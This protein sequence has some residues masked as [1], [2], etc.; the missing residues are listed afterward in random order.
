MERTIIGLAQR[1]AVLLTRGFGF[2]H[3]LEQALLDYELTRNAVD[4]SSGSR[5]C[6][7][8]ILHLSDLHVDGL[9]DGGRRLSALLELTAAD[10][11]LITGD[12]V[13]PAV[14]DVELVRVRLK[15]ILS[16]MRVAHGAFAVL[17]GHDTPHIAEILVDA[18]VTI[19]GAAT[20]QVR[21]QQWTLDLVAA[22]SDRVET[23]SL[24]RN[25]A[26]LLSVAHSPDAAGWAAASRADYLFCGHTHG[27]QV[28]LPGGYP[29]VTR[30]LV[31]R[32]MAR[33]AWAYGALRGYTSRGVG[34]CGGS[35]RVFCRPEVAVHVLLVDR[36]PWTTSA[37]LAD[38]S[39]SGA[40]MPIGP[41]MVHS[42]EGQGNLEQTGQARI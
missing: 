16:S 13:D 17:G 36:D 10:L 27:G 1:A 41:D 12:F 39:G 9:P 38:G 24:K 37:S 26:P 33:G 34:V 4:L 19:L 23:P 15:R 18:G 29:I 3:I 32:R 21:A 14:G 42:A 8:Q 22:S 2:A 5:T 7:V 25:T 31:P 30:T 35:P 28:C 6:Q 20:T 40:I 11:C